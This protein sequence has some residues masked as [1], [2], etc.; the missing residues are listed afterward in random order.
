MAVPADR[1]GGAHLRTAAGAHLTGFPFTAIVEQQRLKRALLLN[2][3]NPAIGGLLVSGPSGTAKSTA[4]RALAELLPEIEVVADCPF[5]CDP[6][7]PACPSCLE[8]VKVGEPLPVR[9]RRRRVVTLP[10]NATEDRVAGTIDMARALMEGVKALEPGLL[11]EANRGILYVDEINLLD[12]HLSD[13]LLDAAASGVNTV[14]R[15]GISV[16]HPARFLLVGTMNP[17]EGDLRPQLADRIGLQVEVEP[18]RDADQRADVIRRREAF[19]SDP[20]ALARRFDVYQDELRDRVRA[21]VHLISEIA[22]P[23][24]LY[25]AIGAL[26]TRLGVESHR[27]DI[28]I[29]ECA[30]AIAALVPRDSVAAADVREAAALALGHRRAG[31]PFG[32]PPRLDEHELDRALEE[33][34]EGAVP[35]KAPVAREKAPEREPAS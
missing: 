28:A 13:I 12:D 22:V 26:V 9:R 14:E 32:P 10:L 16:A 6:A 1:A 35:G 17:E 20:A 24:A 30:K 27:A 31:D 7:A 29:L 4:V 15:E 3:V 18:L 23:D 2:A 19:T 8:R 25:P 34:L 5:V 21:A 33:A 11:A